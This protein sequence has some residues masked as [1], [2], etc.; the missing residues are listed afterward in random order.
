MKKKILSLALAVCTGMALFLSGCGGE[1][2]KEGGA[3]NLLPDPHYENGFNLSTPSPV[4]DDLPSQLETAFREKLMR[5]L[6]VDE[7]TAAAFMN[8]YLHIGNDKLDYNG[9]T[10]GRPSWSLSE[11]SSTYWL[12]DTNYGGYEYQYEGKTSS[13][14]GYNYNEADVEEDGTYVYTTPGKT[15]KVNPSTGELTLAVKG[16]NEYSTDDDHDGIR[17]GVNLVPRT[18]GAQ[19]WVHLLVSGSLIW[20]SRQ[21]DLSLMDSLTLKI[22]FTMEEM[23]KVAPELFN[24]NLHTAQFQLFFVMSSANAADGDFWYGIPFY[25]ARDNE[26]GKVSAPNGGFDAG[27]SM[28]IAS[29]GTRATVG[30]PIKQGKRYDIE[31]DLLKGISDGLKQAQENGYMLNS[32][33]DDLTIANFNLGWEVPGIYDVS[34]AIHNFEVLGEFKE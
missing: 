16:S 32:D 8:P 20:D 9:T 31:F 30:E 33:V 10:Q 18:S 17:D 23:E 27:T 7:T 21:I 22:S 24:Y 2:E 34:V 25:E 15:V 12:G 14:T 29:A 1:T 3:V 11:H 6:S 28:W 4:Y 19:S 5:E 26:E 13:G